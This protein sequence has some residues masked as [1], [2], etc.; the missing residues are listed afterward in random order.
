MML[1]I[2]LTVAVERSLSDCL[3]VMIRCSTKT[4][5]FIMQIL[6]PLDFNIGITYHVGLALKGKSHEKM[7]FLKTCVS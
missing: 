1:C 6:S 4:A 5:D 3:S 7:K 2:S